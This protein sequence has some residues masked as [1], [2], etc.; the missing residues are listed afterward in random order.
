MAIS[1]Q[2][3]GFLC[4]FADGSELGVFY[5]GMI[6]LFLFAWCGGSLQ[7]GFFFWKEVEGNGKEV[8]HG[9]QTSIRIRW[10]RLGS[11]QV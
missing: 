9:L 10:T 11:L 8:H 1:E 5:F 7:K 2:V 3:L 4:S 6:S